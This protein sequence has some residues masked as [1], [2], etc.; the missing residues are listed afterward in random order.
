MDG[1]RGKLR[2]SLCRAC[3]PNRLEEEI[4][5]KTYEQLWPL[6]KKALGSSHENAVEQDSVTSRGENR[7]IAR[8]A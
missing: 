4:W 6:I 1:K 7:P 8:R 5:A 2:R 3:E